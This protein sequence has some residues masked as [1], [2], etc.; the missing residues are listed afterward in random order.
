MFSELGF[1]DDGDEVVSTLPAGALRAVVTRIACQA[2][3]PQ[4]TAAARRQY[5]LWR[6]GDR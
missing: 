5:L 2:M 4:C 3:H 6:D 1:P